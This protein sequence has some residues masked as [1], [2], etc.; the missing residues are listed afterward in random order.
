MADL[1][2]TYFAE[3]I[4]NA[5][6]DYFG[7]EWCYNYIPLWYHLAVC[8]TFAALF[9]A[10]MYRYRGT[11]L[12]LTGRKEEFR[13]N[14]FEQLCLGVG[15]VCLGYTGWL[16]IVVRHEGLFMANPCH[17][18]LLMLL[19]LLRGNNN[20]PAMRWLHTAYSGWTLGA[21]AA[22]LIPHLEGLDLLEQ[23]VFFAE[24]YLIWPLG[25]L[26]LYRRYGWGLPGWRDH[27]TAF[28]TFLLYHLVFLVP[29]GRW[30]KVS[31][32]FQLCPSPL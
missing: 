8:L 9:A 23:G 32:N 29:L 10:M 5:G 26:I 12:S 24:H 14:W 30:T 18:S 28:G 31:I 4:L 19:V 6:Y 25:P 21:F 7:G 15:V 20:S 11:A 16:K 17:V 22:L 13:A 27:F 2:H 1:F 3:G